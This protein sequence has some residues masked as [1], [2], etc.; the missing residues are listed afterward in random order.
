MASLNIASAS[1]AGLSQGGFLSMRAALLAP[2][3]ISSLVLLATRSGLDA[4]ETIENF[5]GLR[6]EWASNGSKNVQGGL[7]DILLGPGVEAAPWTAKWA[8]MG[9]DDMNYPL[10]ALIQRDDITPRLAELK[11]P[12]LV[13]H[14]NAD[15]A[16]DIEHGRKLARDLPGSANICEIDGAGHAVNLAQPAQVT[17]E[18]STFLGS[19]V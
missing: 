5:K 6:S 1:L 11:C 8:S 13:I 14:G 16:I 18:I 19:L 4:S 9:H 2:E 7:A 10:D 15:I 12:S 17:E 3:R